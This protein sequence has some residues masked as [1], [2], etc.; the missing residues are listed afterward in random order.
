MDPPQSW[1]P[2]KS[3]KVQKGRGVG[4]FFLLFHH[5]HHHYYWFSSG[6]VGPLLTCLLQTVLSLAVATASFQVAKPIFCLSPA[7]VLLHVFLGHPLLPRPSGA[8]VRAIRGFSLWSI[9][10]TCPIQYHLRESVHLWCKFYS[11]SPHSV[12]SKP[13][14]PLYL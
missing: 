13:H 6:R 12:V 3:D 1:T 9:H 2:K 4:P 14:Q 11:S 5:H 10:N 8:Q 7:T